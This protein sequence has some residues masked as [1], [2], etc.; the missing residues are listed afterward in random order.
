MQVNVSIVSHM[1]GTAHYTFWNY[2]LL[3]INQQNQ[4]HHNHLNACLDFKKQ[5]KQNKN[6]NRH[7]DELIWQKTFIMK[8]LKKLEN[9]LKTG[10]HK[11]GMQVQSSCIF[12]FS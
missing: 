5:N 7:L 3:N 1:E 12:F 11:T 9:C 2:I 4:Q 8:Q 6:L 10:G